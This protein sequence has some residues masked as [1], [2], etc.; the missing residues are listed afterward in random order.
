M[1]S[2]LRSARVR[3]RI[4]YFLLVGAF[5]LYVFTAIAGRSAP[6]PERVQARYSIHTIAPKRTS[7][8][9]DP[10]TAAPIDTTVAP[11]EEEPVAYEPD[12]TT[13]HLQ[14]TPRPTITA[15]PQALYEHCRPLYQCLKVTAGEEK[16]ERE[17]NGLLLHTFAPLISPM[18]DSGTSMVE[19]GTKD[20]WLTDLWMSV[21]G[22][23]CV[24]F[25]YFEPDPIQASRA[26][27]QIL[28]TKKLH[29]E[30]YNLQR[31][32][33]VVEA[34]VGSKRLHGWRIGEML[35]TAV[36]DLENQTKK[37][38]IL[39]EAKS[40]S[41]RYKK[42]T[43]V[44]ALHDVLLEKGSIYAPGHINLLRL[45]SD[46]I[47]A[48]VASGGALLPYLRRQRIDL[49]L[50][51]LHK[52]SD[53]FLGVTTS[54][55]KKGG[56]PAADYI[57]ILGADAEGGG[58]ESLKRTGL[59]WGARLFAQLMENGYRCFLVSRIPEQV[60]ARENVKHTLDSRDEAM[61][62]LP[63][64]YGKVA[65]HILSS[66][67]D[68][69]GKLVLLELLDYRQPLQWAGRTDIFLAVPQKVMA[70]V[71]KT[72]KPM[73]Y[74]AFDAGRVGDR[75]K[76]VAAVLDSSKAS[77]RGTAA[78]SSSYRSFDDVKTQ[79][80]FGDVMVFDCP[81]ALCDKQGG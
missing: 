68:S 3:R 71:V 27:K 7:V 51:E 43:K 28:E 56:V 57:D 14:E 45:D 25:V 60:K 6:P 65:A 24:N 13:V 61:K 21:F 54:P 81:S 18:C 42:G 64:R 41:R 5:A 76:I 73:K 31:Q 47:D 35:P 48:V 72:A 63:A 40:L 74:S 8:P 66:N 10:T 19:I 38:E 17:V 67:V 22:G 26:K 59:V 78:N 79:P 30:R 33:K 77:C 9:T 46:G 58:G 2:A 49:L 52:R 69:G 55:T 20:G 29:A 15:A 32:V 34:M 12:P 75:E 53:R 1:F 23:S 16:R 36:T 11:L 44:V 62:T 80:C 70:T 50:F 37:V 4:E 39:V